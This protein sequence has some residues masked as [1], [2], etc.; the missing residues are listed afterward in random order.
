VLISATG[1]GNVQAME[2]NLRQQFHNISDESVGAGAKLDAYRYAAHYRA[3]QC[4]G[5]GNGWDPHSM[6]AW[7]RARTPN[8][9][10][11]GSKRA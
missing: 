9:D 4:F 7:I 3:L 5:S 8:Q 2:E 10:P 11:E 6:A 1:T